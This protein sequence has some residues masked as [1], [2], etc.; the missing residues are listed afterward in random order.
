M[1]RRERNRGRATSGG[2]GRVDGLNQRFTR[3]VLRPAVRAAL[4]KDNQELRFYDLRHIRAS[5]TIKTGAHPKVIS[6]HLGHASIGITMDLY[7]HI[8]PFQDGGW[9]RP[10]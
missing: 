10:A 2:P 6:E 8:L 7:S 1:E 5:L 3:D 9:T 4:P